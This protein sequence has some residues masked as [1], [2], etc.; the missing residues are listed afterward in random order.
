MGTPL[1][2]LTNDDG[3]LS[4]GLSAMIKAAREFGDVVVIAPEESQSGKSHAITVE[5]PLRVR[6]RKDEKGL[7]FY[8]C[9]GTPVDCIKLA[10]SQILQRSPDLVL[11]G[12]NHGSNASVSVFYSGTMAAAIEA[13]INKIPAAGFSLNSYSEDADFTDALPYIRM[14]IRNMLEKG[15]EQGVCLNVNI[16]ALPAGDIRGVKVCRQTDGLWKEEFIRRT[17]PSGRDYFWL[18]GFFKNFEAGAEDT[19]EWA[20][21]NQYVSIVPVKIDLTGY[22]HMET[23]NAWINESKV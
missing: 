1:L 11:S 6:K 16:P 12:I 7:L 9:D 2:L 21:Q 3:Y 13:C 23:I 20:L 4:A 18:T 17:D 10:L 14:V 15:L 8:S 5:K 19:D 22:D